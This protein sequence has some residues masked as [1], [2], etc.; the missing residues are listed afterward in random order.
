M[1]HL[2]LILSILLFTESLSICAPDIYTMYRNTSGSSK[3]CCSDKMHS[4]TA[5]SCQK[6]A[7]DMPTHEHGEK[8]SPSCCDD[9]CQCLCCIKIIAQN[10]WP[11]IERHFSIIPKHQKVTG[12]QAWLSFDEPF[13]CYHP[14]RVLCS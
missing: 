6:K 4:S 12:Q 10:Y 3:S 13:K 1:R 5:D 2:A 7:C 9:G 14:P 8:D 11:E